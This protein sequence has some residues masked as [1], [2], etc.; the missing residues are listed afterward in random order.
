[1]SAPRLRLA[2]PDDAAAVRAIYAP[3][4]RDTTV[5]FE[6]Q[7]PEVDEVAGRITRTLERFPWLVAEEPSRILGYAYAGPH[8]DR[9]AYQWTAEVSVYTASDAHRRGLG[10][11]LYTALFDLLRLQGLA[12]ALAGIAQPNPAS[13]A[14]HEALGFRPVGVYPRVGFKHGAWRDVGWWSLRL[15]DGAAPAPPRPLKAWADT[16]ELARLLGS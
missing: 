8:R 14:F 2:T 15:G 13:V 11:A 7:V 16:P 5:S 1:M 9:P 10:R 12:T 3:Y 4:V 6:L